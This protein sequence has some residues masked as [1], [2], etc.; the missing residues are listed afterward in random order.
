MISFYFYCEKIIKDYLST[1]TNLLGKKSKKNSGGIKA[2]LFFSVSFIFGTK[3]L[4]EIC[5]I[6][7][8]KPKGEDIADSRNIST[9]WTHSRVHV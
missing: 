5:K 3:D 9:V 2:K 7:V 1:R 8:R 6:E 4:L